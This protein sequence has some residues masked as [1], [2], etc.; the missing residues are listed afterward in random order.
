MYQNEVSIVIEGNERREA[1]WYQFS[2][3]KKGNLVPPHI[4]LSILSS[5]TVNIL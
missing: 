1:R 5:L 4:F 3:I 2:A